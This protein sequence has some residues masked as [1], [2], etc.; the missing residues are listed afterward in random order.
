MII[1][2]VQ[3]DFDIKYVNWLFVFVL[4]VH[5]FSFFFFFWKGRIV[6]RKF[7]SNLKMIQ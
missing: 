1:V 5:F 2:V 3:S 7:S 6:L 4:I